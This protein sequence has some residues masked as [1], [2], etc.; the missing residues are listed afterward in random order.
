MKFCIALAVFFACHAI[1]TKYAYEMAQVKRLGSV[2][3]W[4][5]ENHESYYAIY[6][7]KWA[8]GCYLNNAVYVPCEEIL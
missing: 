2:S 5:Y 4:H 6:K 7:T 8:R 1:S 3:Y